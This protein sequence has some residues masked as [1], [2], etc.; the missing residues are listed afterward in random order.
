MY[1][2]FYRVNGT[3]AWT[4]KTTTATSCTFTGLKNGTK[5]DFLV[6]AYNGSA[7]STWTNSNVVN[8]TL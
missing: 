6:I 8:A 1:A 4:Q 7:W 5:Y 2:A 3:S